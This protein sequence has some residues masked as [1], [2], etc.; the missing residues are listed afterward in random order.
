MNRSPSITIIYRGGIAVL[1][2]EERLSALLTE[3]SEIGCSVGYAIHPRR[4]PLPVPLRRAR[5]LVVLVKV[6]M[7]ASIAALHRR[8]M[9]AERLVDHDVHPKAGHQHAV[10][11]A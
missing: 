11:V 3:P 8:W 1:A 6:R 4:P 9:R 10:W 2:W 7:I 5:L